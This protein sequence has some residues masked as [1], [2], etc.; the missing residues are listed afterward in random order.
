M[1]ESRIWWIDLGPPHVMDGQSGIDQMAGYW[2]S[3]GGLSLLTNSAAL[4]CSTQV[5]CLS[6]LSHFPELSL[7][8]PLM[9]VNRIG[10]SF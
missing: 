6:G 5:S 10:T 7:M 2:E 9:P 8:I 1:N 3:V 4:S